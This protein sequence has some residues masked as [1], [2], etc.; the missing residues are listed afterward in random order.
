MATTDP[1]RPA[2]SRLG[3]ARVVRPLVRHYVEMVVAMTVGMTVLGVLRSSV[4]L[5]VAFAER[6]GAAYLLMATDMAIGMAVWMRVRRHPW[7]ATLEMCAAM[8][9][10]VALVPLVWAGVVGS[11]TF[12]IAV[13]VLML[14]AMLVVLLRHRH[15]LVR[16]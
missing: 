1:A 2:Q 11:M 6:P 16:C 10:P 5:T 12:M 13:H 9:L 3:S 15:H 7:P 14:A 8:Y 4:G